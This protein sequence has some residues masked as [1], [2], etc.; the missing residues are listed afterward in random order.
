MR[1]T[2]K[3][4]TELVAIMDQCNPS[5]EC[6]L[7]FGSLFQLLIAVTLSAQTT[8]KQ[9]NVVSKDLFEKY[10]D[11]ESMAQAPVEELEYMI[12]RIGMYRTKA[13]NISRIAQILVEEYGGQVPQVHEELVK[14]PG[15]GRKTANVVLAVG[16]GIPAIAVD[17]HVFRVAN[18]IG[19]VDAPDVLKTEQGLMKQIPKDKW[20]DMHHALIWH[21]RRVCSAR[22]PKCDIC[23]VNMLCKYYEKEI[24]EKIKEG[25]PLDK[26]RKL[27]SESV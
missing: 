6:A 23:Q 18:R 1:W 8:D 26:K 25:H 2:K 11:A 16:C 22:S 4:T 13:K 12:R 10:P 14:L 27:E 19:I 7:S 3:K 9:V 5:A 20:I 15:V 17:T 21:G 24:K